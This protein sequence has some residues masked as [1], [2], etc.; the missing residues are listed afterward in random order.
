MTA[1]NSNDQALFAENH[2]LFLQR[3]TLTSQF[4]REPKEKTF[5]QKACAIPSDN[6][7]IRGVAGAEAIPQGKSQLLAEEATHRAPHQVEEEVRP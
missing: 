3:Q 4:T 1:Y 5:P 6:K 2:P 7:P